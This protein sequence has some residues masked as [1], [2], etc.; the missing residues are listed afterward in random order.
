MSVA[1]VP[2]ILLPGLLCDDALWAHQVT[3]LADVAI[4]QVADLCGADTLPMMAAAIL[5]QAPDQFALAGLSMGGYLALEIIR[6]APWRVVRLALLA[7][8]ARA[9]SREQSERR[10]RLQRLAQT[11]RF[12]T[13][14]PMMLAQLLHPEHV[15]DKQL[16]AVLMAMAERIGATAFVRQQQA[17]LE[18]ADSRELL[19]AIRCPTLLICGAQ[20]QLVPRALMQ[21][22]AEVIPGAQLAV[23]ENAGHLLPLE[24]PQVVTALLRDWLQCP[25]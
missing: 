17:I 1:T 10:R 25:L 3:H 15:Q 12:A 14:A 24:Q 8:H 4:P 19:P 7:T 22:M 5:Q 18:R 21:E 23:V 20:D 11:G 16:A 2:L 13:I 6:Q 9:D